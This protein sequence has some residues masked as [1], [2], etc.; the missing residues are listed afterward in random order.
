M[1]NKK[2]NLNIDKYEKNINIYGK[3]SIIIILTL[4]ISY[5]FMIALIFGVNVKVAILKDPSILLFILLW[6][7]ACIVEVVAYNAL[8]GTGGSYIAFVTGNLINLKIPCAENACSIAETKIGTKESELVST[9]S[10]AISSIT[11][12][13]IIVL[14]VA[15]LTPLKPFLENKVLE[16][17]FNTVVF[18]LFGAMG[19]KYFKNYPKL[20][21]LPIITL[22]PVCVFVP[23]FNNVLYLLIISALLS[24]S[25]GL[26]DLKKKRKKEKIFLDNMI[27]PV[28]SEE[29]H[30]NN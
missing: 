28:E 13:L 26:I 4:L 24:I 21:I 11:T 12:T 15:L 27:T 20:I 3:I 18:A 29:I 23:K 2:N 17:G 10:V 6:M 30:I 16:P 22:V 1:K 5:P 14:G 9:I 7:V 19:Y 25:V 8:L